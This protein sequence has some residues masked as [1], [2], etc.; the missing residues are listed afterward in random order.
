M[1]AHLPVMNWSDQDLSEAMSLFKQKMTLYLEDD[2]ITDAAKQARKICRGIGD[3]GLKRLNASGLSDDE[4]KV[5]NTLWNF[6]EGQLKLNVNFRIHRLQLMQYRQKPGE[7]IDDFVT[8]ARTL[9]LKCQFTDEEL[10]ER[11]IELIIAS[12]PHDA[13]RNDLYSKPKGYLITDVLAEGRKYEALSAGNEQLHQL[14]LSHTEKIH[15]MMRGRTCQRCD[16]HHKPH[17]CPAYND[18]CSECGKKGHWMKCCKKNRQRKQNSSCNRKNLQTERTRTAPPG[19]RTQ[20]LFAVRRQCYHLATVP[21]GI[22]TT[23][24]A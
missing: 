4:K 19:D 10:N 20:D 11:L 7:C 15:A 1:A 23:R 16:T 8:R 22:T 13:L 21:P 2:E 6:F 17:Q 18:V 12:T 24:L 3:E 14:G 9:A 5:P